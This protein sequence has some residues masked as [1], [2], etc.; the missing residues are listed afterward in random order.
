MSLVF[1]FLYDTK[2]ERNLDKK[3]NLFY[4]K[5][6]LFKKISFFVRFPKTLQMI[7]F[8]RNVRARFSFACFTYSLF[9]GW[10][11]HKRKRFFLWLFHPWISHR[12]NCQYK[13]FLSTELKKMLRKAH[14]SYTFI[15]ASTCAEKFNFSIIFL[16][17]ILIFKR[18]N[19]SLSK[20]IKSRDV[21]LICWIQ[22]VANFFF[23]FFRTWATFFQTY[24]N[25]LY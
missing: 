10:T 15:S 9:R 18:V 12:E 13:N 3:L 16:I 17:L 7:D 8:F 2:M 25:I 5:L 24:S 1:S 11:F 4:F 6:F 14:V 23:R 19:R 22:L 21:F 20:N